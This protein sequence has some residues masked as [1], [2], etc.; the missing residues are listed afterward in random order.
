[1]STKVLRAQSR[2]HAVERYR[3]VMVFLL[4]LLLSGCTTS[5]K[6]ELN[7]NPAA[8]IRVA[9]LPFV[10]VNAAREIIEEN[11]DLLI[12]DVALISS[13]SPLMPTQFVQRVVRS[14]LKESSALDLIS[15]AVVQ[16]ELLHHGFATPDLSLDRRKLFATPTKE[17]CIHHLSC[18]AIL[19]GRITRWDRRYYGIESV[20]TVGVDLELISATDGAVLFRSTSV[21]SDSRGLTKGPTG[22][23]DLLIEPLKGLDNKLVTDLARRVVAEAVEPLRVDR[24]PEFLESPPPAIFSSAHDGIGGTLSERGY[25]TVVMAGTEKL[26]ATFSVG[27]LVRSIP[28]IERTPGGYIGEYH[29]LPSDSFSEAP[30]VV[31]LA[32]VHGRITRQRIGGAPLTL[33]R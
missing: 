20:T 5:L 13:R 12:D 15:P 31:E 16:G 2:S 7:F 10:Q 28:M 6:H 17:I 29:P 3:G 24:R 23:S 26:T 19:Y 21:D 4:A 18:D 33:V 27:T 9:I 1:M 11:P 8:P 30:I 32:D 25:L 22:F 14:S